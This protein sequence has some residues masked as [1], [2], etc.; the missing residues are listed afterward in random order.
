MS[1]PHRIASLLPSATEILF[2][3]GLGNRVVAVSHECDYPLEVAKLPRATFSH[4]DR[5]ASSRS[6]DTAVQESLQAGKSL[7]GIDQPL[8]ERLQCDLI[9]TQSQC[10][11]CAVKYSDVLEAIDRMGGVSR[12]P[13]VALNPHSL[14]D[15]LNDIIH[16]GR[17]CA[18][19][20]AAERYAAGLSRRV[21]DVVLRLQDLLAEERPRTVLLEWIDPLMLAGNWMPEI[22]QFAGGVCALV[23]GKG[24]SPYVD[25]EQIVSYDPEVVIVCPCGFDRQRT[26]VEAE[27]LRS[28]PAWNTISAVQHDRVFAVDGNAYFNRSGP[29]LVETL[30][31][32]AHLLHPS[33]LGP[34]ALKKGFSPPWCKIPVPP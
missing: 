7:Y 17:T 15:V 1:V 5:A 14:S 8:L 10:D 27:E 19:Q 12:V 23:E 6:I 18:Q 13:I 29:R 34:P 4:M 25:W 20:E 24:H 21:E 31:I 30:E 26:V 33:R 2:G 9:I 32:L 22:L 11:V 3:L 16:V 28:L